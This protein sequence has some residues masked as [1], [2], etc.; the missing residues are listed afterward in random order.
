[1]RS[2]LRY[3]DT[4]LTLLLLFSAVYFFATCINNPDRNA[5]DAVGDPIAAFAGEASCADC[6]KDIYKAHIKTGHFNSS[7][8]AGETNILGSFNDT[9]NSFVFSSRE[10]IQMEKNAG[11]FFQVGYVD[12]VEKRRQR[13]D[14]VIGS[15][16][17]GQSFASWN[18]N[19]LVQLPITYFTPALAWSNSPGYPN[20]IAFNRPI[21]ARCMECHATYAS[22][23]QEAGTQHV[24]FNQGK[25][26]LGITCE[27]CHGA[28]DRHVA[29][30][31]N[32]PN[33]TA[34]KFITNP[35]TFTRQQSLD[36]CALCHGG[37]LEATQPAFSFTAGA[38]LA[39][40]FHKPA[41]TIDG[42][43]IDVHGNQLALLEAS[44]C[45]IKSSALTC[46][47]CHNPHDNEKGNLTLFSQKCLTCHGD[48][49][50]GKGICKMTERIGS[51]INAN[52][53]DC[54]MPKQQS[55]AIAVML[56]GK[57]FPTPAM[58]RTHL[59]QVYPDETKA[60]LE[61]FKT[62]HRIKTSL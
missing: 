29:Y 20:R 30:Q 43:P 2:L 9:A 31:R 49:H 41:N 61:Y 47:T 35:K 26:L 56:Q 13:F 16:N 39:D 58:I 52:C 40:F 12:D 3:R 57:Q 46:I 23:E 18:G 34:A 27:R 15:G 60:V 45:F 1:M 17:K 5:R 11:G 38:N 48:K 50:D 19:K 25:L 62:K 36:M 24:L 54:H 53:I 8:I 14:I 42:N 4:S 22:I 32:Q 55:M 37:R 7:A 10:E 33:T 44:K 28:A 59:V 51:A 6:H 21:T